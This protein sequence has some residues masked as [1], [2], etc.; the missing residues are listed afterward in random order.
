MEVSIGLTGIFGSIGLNFASCEI[1]SV[2]VTDSVAAFELESMLVWD[3]S[4]TASRSFTD[5]VPEN[6]CLC[7]NLAIFFL[8]DFSGDA[9]NFFKWPL[10]I[11]LK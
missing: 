9:E 7:D 2:A 1:N 10:N 4:A 11:S 8:F 5:T 6:L 3:E